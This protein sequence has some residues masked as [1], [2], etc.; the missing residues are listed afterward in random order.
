[1]TDLIFQSNPWLLPTLTLIVLGLSIEVP[2]RFG[3]L[4][5]VRI[6][7][8]DSFDAVH[9][10]ILTL[11]AFVLA[12]SFNQASARFDTRRALVVREA[13][14]IGTTWLRANQLESKESRRFRQILTNYT[15]ARLQAY[16][17]P[18]N[19]ALY[20]ATIDQGDKDKGELWA[21]ASSAL[22]ARPSNLGLSL[23]MQSTNDTI[24]VSLEQ[25]QALTTHVPTAIVVL[26][27]LLVILGTLSLGLRFA[28]DGS[29][30]AVLSAIYVIAYVLVI[31]MMVDYDRPNTG[32][33]RVSVT[34][35]KLQLQSMQRSP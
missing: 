33:V 16:E 7:K 30:P 15:A 14:T 19:P 23:L 11:S 29:R 6:S 10:G 12:L 5:A 17:A 25:L 20:K 8:P 27:L 34:P 1:M 22:K 9:A 24:D 26:T 31:N 28:I 18:R 21:I 32:F 2:Y 35:L 4:L 3:P 13:N